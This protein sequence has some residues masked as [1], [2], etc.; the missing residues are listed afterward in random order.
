MQTPN[1]FGR[2]PAVVLSLVSTGIALAAGFGL[3]ISTT[4]IGLIMAF[5]TAAMGWVIRSRVSPATKTS[6]PA[7]ASDIPSS[8]ITG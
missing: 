7:E 4:Q 5:V 1:L 2:E 6:A 3:N 8:P